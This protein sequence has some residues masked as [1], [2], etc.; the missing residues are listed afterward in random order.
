[1]PSL[2][3]KRYLKYLNQNQSILNKNKTLTSFC[4]P[5]SNRGVV[6]H[7]PWWW[8]R[9][10]WFKLVFR[11]EPWKK[12]RLASERSQDAM[13]RKAQT[14]EPDFRVHVEGMPVTWFKSTHLV[15][16]TITP[17]LKQG[18]ILKIK[19]LK[20]SLAK[21]RITEGLVTH[22]IGRAKDYIGRVKDYIRQVKQAYVF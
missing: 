19:I 21:H 22:Y 15:L 2:C 12:G 6:S 5:A 17:C 20:K 9:R 13:R 1:M 14:E 3:L 11:V 7:E 4:D 16:F 18:S 10:T 8:W